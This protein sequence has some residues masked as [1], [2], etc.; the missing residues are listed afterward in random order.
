MEAARLP[1]GRVRVALIVALLVLA[2]V[3]WLVVARRMNGMDAGPGTDPGAL[4]FYTLSWV[5]MMAAMMF[6]SIVPMVLV[7]A[8][9]Q[10][11]RRARGALEGSVSTS[12][13]VAGYL[14]SWTLFGLAAYAAFSWVRSL[15]IGTFSWSH[16]GRYVASGVLVAAAIY[17]LTPAKDACLQRCRGPLDFVLEHWREGPLGALRMG[18]IHGAWCVGCCWA[19]MAALFA[20]G[21]MSVPWMIVVAAMIAG[22]KLLPSK[23]LANRSV[24]TALLLLGLGVALAP[25]QVPG[26][27]LPTSPAAARAR[28]MMHG[29]GMPGMRRMPTRHPPSMPMRRAPTMHTPTMPMR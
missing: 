15:S 24:A 25:R 28:S 29:H 7:F 22:E 12:L 14:V 18:T 20:L 11:R 23:T 4:G 10:R 13:F 8:S 9:V 16:D 6:P 19:L 2:A 26:L 5:V 1:A 27:T 21:V 3:A 17:Q